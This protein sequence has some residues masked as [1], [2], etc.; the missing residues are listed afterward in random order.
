M[1]PFRAVFLN[2][3][4]WWFL[5]DVTTDFIL[6]IDLTLNFFKPFRQGAKWIKNYKRTSRRYLR[7]WFLIDFIST[8][9]AYAL[10][11]IIGADATDPRLRFNYTLLFS[12]VL[13]QFSLFERFTRKATVSL[14]KLLYTLLVVAHWLACG[15]VALS[16]YEGWNT[17]NN[18]TNSQSFYLPNA[19]VWYRYGLGMYWVL[20]TMTGFG[21]TQPLTDN[22]VYY[23]TMTTVVGI[24]FYA[25]AIAIAGDLISNYDPAETAFNERYD[26]IKDFMKNRRFPLDLNR[27]VIDYYDYL[28]HSRKGLDEIAVLDD[29]PDFLRSEVA[30]HLN[31]SIIEKVPIFKGSSQNFLSEVVTHLKPRIALPGSYIIRIGEF[32]QEMFFISTGKVAI[33]TEQGLTVAT[34]EDGDFFGE[35]ALVKGVLRTA[36]VVAITFCDLV[37]RFSTF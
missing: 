27:H 28:W 29:L 18:W 26:K 20:V 12:R 30:M 22:E 3:S 11:A 23:N 9:P 24:A 10:A 21:G 33:Q 36:N 7:T 37:I 34:L 4:V 5:P 8:F 13:A 6:L 17:S 2:S 25:I 31:R 32:G 16:F 19:S 14:I 1:I 35:I 15:M